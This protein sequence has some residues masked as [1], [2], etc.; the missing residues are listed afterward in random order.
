M[1]YGYLLYLHAFLDG[2]GAAGSGER[3]SGPGGRFR[4]HRALGVAAGPVTGSRLFP[5]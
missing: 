3:T 4:R 2:V 5:I 1:L